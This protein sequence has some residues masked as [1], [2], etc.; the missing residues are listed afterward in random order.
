[1][2]DKVSVIVPAYNAAQHLPKCLDSILAQTY[3]NLELIVVN[4]G[5]R[6]NTAQLLDAYAA[7][8]SSIKVIHKSNGGVSSAR[9]WGIREASGEWIT[10]VDSDDW[11]EPRGLEV[12]MRNATA[13]Q[14][15]ISHYGSQRNLPDGRVY[16]YYN[17][18]RVVLQ[19]GLQGCK[20]LLEGSFIEP[21]IWNKLYKKELFEGLEAW[22]D[23][24]IK[25]NE[26][27]L[28]NYYL[29]KKANRAIF[30]D[31]CPYH[32][33]VHP[34][35]AT[36]AALN[37]HLVWDSLRV[38]RIILKDCPKDVYPVVYRRMIRH[39]VHG[40]AM[41]CGDNREL[42][43]P[44]R[45]EAR[46][47]LRKRIGHVLLGQECNIKL[48]VMALWAAVWPASFGWIHR[49]YEKVSGIRKKYEM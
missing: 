49:I 38:L 41:H 42:L 23:S 1:M 7:R 45:K 10:F 24:S 46:R 32:Y 6:D 20:D 16:Y 12:L 36:T 21:G 29:F 48:K 26:D 43:A 11:V 8:F 17:T 44:Y 14:A 40:A 13:Y 30:E 25:I 2:R 15:D 3:S 34:G 5:S 37:E 35:S 4:D 19:E 31:I 47:D 9:M 22:L 28:V 18:G 39:L 27:L 33:I